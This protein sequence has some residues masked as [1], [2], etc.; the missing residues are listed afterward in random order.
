MITNIE[1]T[2]EVNEVK[3]QWSKFAEH[4]YTH[5]TPEERIQEYW[6]NHPV[7]KGLEVS[8]LGRV[9]RKRYNDARGQARG[10]RVLVPNNIG[11]GY[12]Q[13]HYTENGKE[14]P[15][16]VHRLVLETFGDRVDSDEL[17]VDHIVATPSDNRYVNLQWLP[18]EENLAKARRN[19][20][21]FGYWQLFS[22]L[23]MREKDF[24]TKEIAL[25]FYDP[26]DRESTDVRKATKKGITISDVEAVLYRGAYTGIVSQVVKD[27]PY[28]REALRSKSLEMIE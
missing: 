20:S 19:G 4:R 10:G 18:S 16:L 5:I 21:K 25:R 15:L 8:S 14:K 23:T 17:E 3:L 9:Y 13:V 22:I 2:L 7:H 6:F 12:L 26:E 27:Y 24:T 11:K 1:G 28:L